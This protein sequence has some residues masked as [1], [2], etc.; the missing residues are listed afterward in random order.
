VKQILQSARTGEIEVANVPSPRV[1]PGCVLVKVEASLVSAGTERAVAEFSSKSLFGKARSRPDLVRQVVHKVR[2]DGILS[3]ANT[4]R[5]R[6]DQ[7][8]P[9]GY[10]CAGT[11]VEIGNG[12]VD[13]VPGDRVACAGAGFAVHAEF[14]S[15]PRLLVARV[16]PADIDFESA[17]FT[18]LGAVAI[19]AIRTAEAK[20]GEVVAVIGLGLLGQLTVQILCAA[21]CSVIGVD[22]VSERAAL[23]VQMGALAATTSEDEF[24]DLCLRYSYG[25][26]VDSILIAAET[27]SCGPVNLAAEVARDRGIVVAIGTV[28]ME[29]Q[30]KPYYEKELDFRISR[31]YGPGRYDV[32]FEQ[33]GRDYP[34]GYV[35]WSETR[36]MEAFLQLIADGKLKLTPLISHR[37]AID[38]ALSAYN[39]I[40]GKLKQPHL[41]VLLTYPHKRTND[42]PRLELLPLPQRLSAAADVRV[43]LL[44][45]GNFANDVL[46]PAI[47]NSGAQLA[48]LCT[49]TGIRGKSAAQKF[50]FEFC[51]TDEGQIFSDRAI[52]TV[53]IATRHHLH[54]AQVIRALESGKNVFCEKPVC[55]N[56]EELDEIQGVYSRNSDCRVMVGF[57]RRFAPFAVS[58]KK[59]L[60][61]VGGPFTMMYRV[62]A[63]PLP[64]DHWI[65]DPEEGGGR[66]VGEICHFVD[67]LSFMCES[68][69]ISV[70]ATGACS[71]AGQDVIATIHFLNDSVGTLIYACNGDR[72]FSKERL[73]VFGS[74]CTAVLEDF[75]T[76]ELVQHGRKKPFRSFFRQDKGHTA[77]WRAF[78][79][80]IRSGSPSPISF[81]EIAASTRAT[82]RIAESLRSRLE[83]SVDAHRVTNVP[84]P[85]V[86]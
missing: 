26:G 6:L 59:F 12:I 20:L 25:R 17:A 38:D 42:N 16:P 50:G 51:T 5:S 84:A 19:H 35:R 14:A 28:G 49:A 22:P 82:I 2:R 83:L 77:E 86:S 61:N 48:G 30:R 75:R 56:E 72:A 32:A 18:T 36:N 40:T 8:S 57:N 43:G 47:K 13:L 80:C 44:G 53:V 79:E 81:E 1:T 33:K 34:I 4:V 71:S 76:L 58:M 45:A 70:S 21:G 27:P 63:G 31:S 46:I 69:P 54:A 9:L 67:L 66:I 11:I 10:S 37:F 60:S 15:V 85:L 3:A 68:T 29:L 52:N 73:E 23:A 39:L 55:F 78:A 65:N 62:N 24:R 64:S 7:P 74:G 41:G